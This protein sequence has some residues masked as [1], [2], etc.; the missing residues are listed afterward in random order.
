MRDLTFNL[1]NTPPLP[2]PCLNVD[3]ELVQ[4]RSASTPICL[5][6]SPLVLQKLDGQDRL[7]EIGHSVDGGVSQALCG[8][9]LSMCYSIDSSHE[10]AC[11]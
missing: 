11:D 3:T 9:V 8:F 1:A 2:G 10:H 7:T 4:H 6:F 5:R